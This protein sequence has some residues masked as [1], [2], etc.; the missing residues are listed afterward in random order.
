MLTSY[1]GVELA[2]VLAQQGVAQ[3]DGIFPGLGGVEQPRRGH[4][5]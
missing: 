3:D 4:R 5:G 1:A 2:G